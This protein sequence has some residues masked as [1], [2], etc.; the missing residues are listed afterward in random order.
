MKRL[1]LI[2]LVLLSGC[3][4]SEVSE[5]G[6]YSNQWY[7]TDVPEGWIV[8]EAE[9]G[10]VLS[11]LS[12]GDDFVNIAVEVTET[13]LTL[14]EVWDDEKDRLERSEWWVATHP[15][16]EQTTTLDSEF[17]YTIFY[18]YYLGQPLLAQGVVAVHDGNS[19]IVTLQSVDGVFD[20]EYATLEASL[21]SFGFNS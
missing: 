18:E 12:T 20:S 6:V 1:L 2:L 7:S 21:N 3:A 8:A 19:F 13:D 5:D 14:S 15:I 11:L 4:L 17:A 9:D 16:Q 10:R